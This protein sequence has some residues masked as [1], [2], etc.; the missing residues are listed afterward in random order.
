MIAII[1]NRN[2]LTA[3]LGILAFQRHDIPYA[4]INTEETVPHIEMGSGVKVGILQ[5]DKYLDAQVFTGIWFRRPRYYPSNTSVTNE[6]KKFVTEETRAAWSNFYQLLGTATWV[7]HPEDNLRAA[8][9]LWVL[10]Q[11]RSVGLVTPRT[12][13]TR[14]SCQAREFVAC[15]GPVVA[16]SIGPGYRDEELGV[17]SFATYFPTADSIPATLG[18]TPVLF[19]NYIDKVCDWRVTVFGERVY[20][21]RLWSQSSAGGQVDWRQASEPVPMEL[22]SLPTSIENSIRVLLARLGLKFAAID[23]VES[24]SGQLLFLEVNANGQWGWIE[25]Q[26]GIP[27]SD[28]LAYLMKS[29]FT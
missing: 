28:G 25:Q 23:L 3:D 4:R 21:V 11:A 12:L 18:S 27:I 20:A 17:A 26:A 24:P 7:N 1:T 9:R 6:H 10:S 5:E 2:D 16:K 14:S 29:T 15:N 8:N 13:I 22:S 19:Q